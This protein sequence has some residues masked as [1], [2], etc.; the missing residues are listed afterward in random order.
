MNWIEN[1]W[2]QGP[3]FEG[4]LVKM[5]FNPMNLLRE[6]LW[7]LYDYLEYFL[8]VRF[9]TYFHYLIFLRKITFSILSD[10]FLSLFAL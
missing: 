9:G 6:D 3:A 7:L 8:D 10:F 2:W 1:R 4:K 5:G